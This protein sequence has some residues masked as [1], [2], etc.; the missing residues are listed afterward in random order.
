MGFLAKLFGRSD[1]RA[2][3]P[4]AYL[5]YQV[6]PEW[7]G[8][9]LEEAPGILLLA[10]EPEA[11]WQA[12]IFVE[13]RTDKEGRELSAALDDLNSNLQTHKPGFRLHDK[14]VLTNRAGVQMGRVEYSAES[15]GTPLTEWELAIP[16]YD[17]QWFFILASAASD[18]WPKYRALFSDFVDSIVVRGQDG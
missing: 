10:P 13:L 7:S 16:F 12:N 5:D 14:Q 15:E 3:D 18:C 6:P 4:F 8:E 9:I 17:D 11:D 1:P 2:K